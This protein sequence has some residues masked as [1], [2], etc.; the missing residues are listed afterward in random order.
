M[1]LIHLSDLH[2][3]KKLNEYPLLEDQEHILNQIADIVEHEQPDAVLLAG[4]IYDKSVPS[5]E[6]VG[7]FDEFLFRLADGQRKIFVISGNHDS[8]E[9]LAFGSRL[10][11]PSGVHVAPV[12]AGP[13]APV[14]IEGPGGAADIYMLPFV[15]PAHVRRYFPDEDIRSY[16]EAIRL[17]AESLPLDPDVKNILVTH[18]FVAGATLCESED[19]SVGGS[20]AVDA[21]LFDAFDY[22]ALGH[23]HSPQSVK[24]PQVR[25]PGSPLKYSFSEVSHQKSVTVLEWGEDLDKDQSGTQAPPLEPQGEIAV[26]TVDLK[27]LRGMA[28]LRGSYR[29]LMDRSFYRDRDTQAFIRVTLTDEQEIP[30]A[31]ANLRI[32]YPH[33]LR[34]DYDNARTRAGAVYLEAERVRDKPPLEVFAEFYEKQNSAPLSEEGRGIV[35]RAIEEIWEVRP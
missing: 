23:L 8:P 5:A 31:M 2:I 21:S 33:I 26:R 29:D 10:M 20:E 19:I 15:R 9:R 22:V 34:L 13:P 12:F 16:N 24:R 27:P 17:I 28:E 18:Q 35:A 32:V 7:L 25:Y 1:K 6:A 3:G 11:I 4:D 30:G 14:R